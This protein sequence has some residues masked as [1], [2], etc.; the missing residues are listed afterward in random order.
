MIV[1]YA[2]LATCRPESI[3]QEEG[4]AE[5]VHPQEE[6]QRCTGSGCGACIKQHVPPDCTLATLHCT[7][8]AMHIVCMQ[9]TDVYV[10]MPHKVVLNINPPL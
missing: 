6:R 5:H 7:T 2:T 3:R 1:T 8:T 9:P 4:A 10:H